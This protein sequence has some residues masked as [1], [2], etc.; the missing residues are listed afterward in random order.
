MIEFKNNLA[1]AGWLAGWGSAAGLPAAAAT[2]SNM[3]CGK[4]L[5]QGFVLSVLLQIVL[6][7]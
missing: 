5:S 7:E 2:E 4:V 6:L 3:L 1:L